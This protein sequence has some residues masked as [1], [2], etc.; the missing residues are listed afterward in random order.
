MDD[1]NMQQVFARIDE[2]ATHY[3]KHPLWAMLKSGGGADEAL[4]KLRAF[5]PAISHFILGFRDFNDFV[6]PYPNPS[7]ALEHA[8]NNHALEDSTHFRDLAK[9]DA[10]C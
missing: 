10:Q 1:W 8:I 7:T 4:K 3:E 2:Q 6:L 5:A 9:N